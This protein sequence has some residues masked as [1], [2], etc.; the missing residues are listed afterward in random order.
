[1]TNTRELLREWAWTVGAKLP[2]VQWIL[3]DLDTWELNPHYDGEEQM[4]PEY[5][6]YDEPTE[7]QEWHDFDPDC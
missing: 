6:D 4:H 3:S 2:D 1:M 7:A 5:E